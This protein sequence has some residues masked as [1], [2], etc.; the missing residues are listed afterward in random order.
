VLALEEITHD[1]RPQRR[2]GRGGDSTKSPAHAVSV[3]ARP[4]PETDSTHGCTRTALACSTSGRYGKPWSRT[5]PSSL[6]RALLNR[7]VSRGR[8]DDTEEFICNRM[9][10]Y[11]D[12]TEPL[13]ITATI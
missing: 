7:L 13:G 4:R 6:A 3:S 11:R 8:A 9:K 12:E 10:L 1:D 2:G 5:A